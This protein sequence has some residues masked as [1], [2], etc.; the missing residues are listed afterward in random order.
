[1]RA[2]TPALLQIGGLQRVQRLEG[3]D[4]FLRALL[5]SDRSRSASR[6]RRARLAPEGIISEPLTSVSRQVNVRSGKV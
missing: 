4:P 3:G 1:M 6:R 5:D 2:L